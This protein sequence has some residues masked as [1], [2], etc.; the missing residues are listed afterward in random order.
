MWFINFLYWL[1]AFFGPVIL[2]GIT[3]LA[4]GKENWIIPL[5]V[6]GGIAGIILAEFIRRHIGL[7][8]FFSRIYGPNEMDKKRRNENNKTG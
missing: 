5:L 4:I 1:Q 6:T 8:T 7:D 2:M 3:A